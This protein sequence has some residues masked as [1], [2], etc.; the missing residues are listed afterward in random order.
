[1]ERFGVTE[2]QIIS[3]RLDDN[4]RA[5]MKF[6]I[7]RAQMYYD[8]A[9]RGVPM[10][11]PESRLPVQSSLDCYG[12][13]LDK[14][15]ENGYDTLTKRAYVSKWEKLA[16]IPFSWY[17]TLDISKVLPIPGDKN[18]TRETIINPFYDLSLDLFRKN[19][20]DCCTDLTS[21]GAVDS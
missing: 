11:S 19:D 4:Y 12:K 15:E 16:T 20:E 8:R 10:L 7:D 2:E 3:Q 21:S 5:M 13:I 14:I 17:R 1:M 9:L 6:Q 18:Q